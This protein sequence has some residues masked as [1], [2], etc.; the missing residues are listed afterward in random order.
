M[1]KQLYQKKNA[2]S[3]SQPK[4]EMKPFANP[5]KVSLFY[6]KRILCNLRI[7]MFYQMPCSNQTTH[8]VVISKVLH[9]I[10]SRDTSK[11]LKRKNKAFSK[12][13]HKFF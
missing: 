6:L 7:F 2:I 10:V 9:F 1:H 12:Y 13:L 11:E 8:L 5:K 3:G 4:D